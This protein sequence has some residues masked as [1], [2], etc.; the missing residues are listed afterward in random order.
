MDKLNVF[1]LITPETIVTAA[2]ASASP[3]VNISATAC[4]YLYKQVRKSFEV[5][6]LRKKKI[7]KKSLLTRFMRR[8]TIFCGAQD[9]NI[10][11]LCGNVRKVVQI[12]PQQTLDQVC[13]QYNIPMWGTWFS[14]NGKP[15]KTDIPLMEYMVYD[16]ASIIQHVRCLGG[17]NDYRLYT[18]VYECEQMLLREVFV[19]Q[20]NELIGGDTPP[21]EMLE[22]IAG[23]IEKIRDTFPTDYAWL[24]ELLE[25][26]FQVLY[27][28]RKCDTK[29][30]Y[31]T[32]TMLAYKLVT[33]KSVSISLWNAFGGK[34]LQDDSFTKLTRDARDMFNVASLVVDN[35]LTKKLR[36]IYTYLFVQGFMSRVG[37]EI[38][39]E[40]FLV[41]DAKTKSGKSNA[42]MA[43][44]IIDTG[45][46]ICERIDTY[47]VTGDWHALLHDDVT[48][49]AWVKEAERLISLAPFTSNLIAH[50]TTYFRFI[51][52]LN[53][54]VERG[55]A[56]CKYSK[57]HSGSE[58]TLMRKRLST[59][60]LIK[61]TEITRRASQKERKAPFGV[62]IHGGSS[63]G[64]SSFTKML[65]YYFGKI[66]GLETD[67]HYRYVR[68]PT[69][70]Y[71]SNFDSS[72]W[73]IQMD[74]IA[75][76]L[77]SKS[78]EVDPTLK[79]MLNVVN[80]VPYVPPQAALED[81]GK[82]P[83]MAKLVLATTNAADLNALEYFHCPLAVR[84]RLPYVIHVQPKPEYLASNGKF[85]DPAKVPQYED[86][87]PDLWIIE[88]QKLN[89]IEHCGR[90]SA[91]LETVAVFDDVKA[92]LKHFAQASHV[93]E[94]NQASSDACD[95]QMRDVK[96]CPLCYEIG[97]DCEC[98]QG[99]VALPLIR[100][101]LVYLASCATDIAMKLAIQLL[102]STIYM[103][104]CR[105]Y[106]VRYV[107]VRWTRFINQG[108]E[109]KFHG[110]MNSTR[111][112]KFKIAVKHL[113]AA[114]FIALNFLACYKV[115]KWTSKIV[116]S[117]EEASKSATNN[118]GA[119][120]DI[121]FEEESK[122]DISVPTSNVQV[123]GNVHGTTEEQLAKEETHN[124]W[125][126]PTL[127]LNKF[128]V[129][130]A[131]K[132]LTS[133]TPAAIRDLFANNCVKIEVEAKDATWKIRMGAVFVRGQY[134]LFNRHAL[135]KGTQF[136]MKIISMTQSQGLTSN[137]VC[138]FSRNEVCEIPNKDIALLR[139]TVVPPR[140]DI[141]KFWNKTQIPITRMMAVRRTTEGN[142]EYA[143]Y[144]NAQ[145][146]DSFP[147]EALNVEMD[148]YMASGNTQTKDGDCGSIGIAITPQGPIIMGI[149]TLGYKS[150]AVFPHITSSDIESLLEPSI[151]SVQGGDETLLNLNGEVIL[152]E[153][154]YK[155]IL[156]YMPEGTVNIYGSLSGFR[157]KPRSRVTTTPL[158]K[159]MC[160]HFNYEIGFGQP[161]MKGWEPYYN[162]V[163]EMVKPHTNI[164]NITLDKCIKGYLS[165]VLS[166]LEGVHG[167]DWKGQLCFL[168][169]R[170]ALNGL[171]GVK[172]IDR[173]NISTSMGH[174]W[175]TTKKQYLV[176][177]P[178]DKY[179]EGVD[180]TPEVWER[181]DFIMRQYSEGKRVYPVFTGHLKDEA[182]AFRKIKAKKTRVFTGAPADWSVVVRSRLLSFVRLL[183]KNKFIFE[184]APG[185]VA[186]S[187]EWTQFYEYLTAH[188]LDQLVAGDYGKFDKRMISTFVLAAFEIIAKIHQEA[189]FNEQ[190]VRE[191][192]CI[193]MDTA[194]PVTNMAGD[195]M[196]FFGTNP[197]GHPLTV[198][199]NCIV[200]SLYMR[201][202]YC[203]LNPNGED[204]TEFK[205]HV[206]LLTYGDDNVL[207]VSPS[208]CWFNHTNIQSQL[209]L[210][211][212]EYTMADKE[213]ES[214]PFININ[215][216]AFL[217]R[218][219]RFEK[220][221]G[222][223]VCPLEELSIHKSLTTWVPSQ[224]IDEYKQ[225]VAVITSA[226][227]EYFFYGRTEFEKHHFFF[228]HILQM[229]PY[230]KYVE[231]TTLPGWNDLIERFRRA[232]EPFIPTI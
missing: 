187:Y 59:L 9:M 14:L 4:K 141:I 62:L 227:N 37:K 198:I 69:D 205:Q 45:L 77:P 188:G 3:V 174:P 109:L 138:H 81:K 200:N 84:R 162:N 33:G 195:L 180:F 75:F 8:Q 167:D 222:M 214:K 61:N 182:T 112:L 110:M 132:S 65:Y 93:H 219:W 83:V 124:V 79:E 223:F 104:L 216:C 221:L 43:M 199:V 158:V 46:T 218:T 196:E 168:S 92:F 153:P 178:D 122:P 150:T 130:V 105:F 108:L 151:S 164:D 170:A 60:Q 2:D 173:I 68:N 113:L 203:K 51:S 94:T 232:S 189:G 210:I 169:K 156:R 53:D 115:A 42:S 154:H 23:V 30:D 171:P 32:C 67:D 129:P 126:N 56:I 101:V 143:E 172:F 215:E 44:L 144:Y 18:H 127:E 66:H 175:N 230:N 22:R 72:K 217:K 119:E 13:Y 121:E 10:F 148:V 71:W 114:G 12:H 136:Q 157:P 98:L 186:Q 80:N 117:N 57:Q 31:I 220:E 28:L 54:S 41:L 142:V 17:N 21:V 146:I 11:M 135:A 34:D 183:Q 96:V 70:E 73:C 208:V 19:L 209:A 49:T 155:S 15:L 224:T 165:D 190:E 52:D 27:W 123:Q 48:Y 211:G 176:S 194:F 7:P 26:I 87:F 25:N 38:S 97:N 212:I 20:A 90:D 145:Y 179:P 229:E 213:A 36:L 29:M 149:H 103:W 91:S 100:V 6:E 86:C 202:A 191:I 40:E 111:E 16:N 35:P 226:N 63:V 120:E 193:G 107:T 89:P 47:R 1:S 152:G 131:S 185:A 184:A 197:S 192:Y 5:H 88:V 147:V 76:L 74:D 106:L 140:K 206:N 50:G 134:L 177:A 116:A 128:D 228:Q 55:D 204:C 166:G 24:G 201:Y 159:E 181:V 161:V 207:G 231:E 225:M 125:Y 137:S 64:K 95:V 99:L 139:V 102:A 133:M 39:V 118:V 163:V 58:S 82:T 78:S 85:L 160:E